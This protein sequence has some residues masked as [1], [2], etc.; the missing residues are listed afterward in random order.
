MASLPSEFR[1][2]RFNSYYGGDTDG[3]TDRQTGDV[4]SLL[5]FLESRL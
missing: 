5:S 4:I 1:E 2:N 3:D